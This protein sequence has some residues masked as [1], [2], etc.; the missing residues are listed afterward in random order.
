[1]MAEK[2]SFTHLEQLL[3]QLGFRSFLTTQGYRAI[4]H[5]SSDTLFVLPNY[6]DNERVAWHHLATVRR[7]LDE[8]GLMASDVFDRFVTTTSAIA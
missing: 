8:R 2:V 4:A 3:T 5:E 7:M 6:G 1:M